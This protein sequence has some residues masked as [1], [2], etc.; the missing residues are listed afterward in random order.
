MENP[1]ERLYGELI[2][3]TTLYNEATIVRMLENFELLLQTVA[4]NPEIRLSKL[5]QVLDE[6]DRKHNIARK[7][8]FKQTK[9]RSLGSAKPKPVQLAGIRGE[10]RYEQTT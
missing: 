1:G 7:E 9:R 3:N 8:E 10:V 5:K 4:T 6:A 2:Y